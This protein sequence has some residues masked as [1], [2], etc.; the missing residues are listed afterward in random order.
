MAHAGGRPTK[1]LPEFIVKVSEYLLLEQDNTDEVRLPTIEGFALHIQ[2]D[3]SS[4]YEWAG[5][6]EEFSYALG[7]IL[8]EQQKRL[9]NKGLAGKYNP[10]IAKLILSANHGMREKTDV[11][12]NDKDIPTPIYGGQSTK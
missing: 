9:V 2:V 12:T 5:K 4:L 11:T 10:T 3:K 1:Y 8:V 6:H 7:K